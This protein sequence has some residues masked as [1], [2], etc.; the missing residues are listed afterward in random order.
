VLEIKEEEAFLI[1]IFVLVK[2]SLSRHT[3]LKLLFLCWS[4]K[5]L[6]PRVIAFYP[7]PSDIL[8]SL[9]SSDWKFAAAPGA[10]YME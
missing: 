9:F 7:A 3:E 4:S 8:P 10:A 5:I 6:S 2:T 1:L